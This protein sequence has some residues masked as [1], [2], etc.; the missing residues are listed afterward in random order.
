[1]YDPRGRYR[2]WNGIASRFYLFIASG[3]HAHQPL[4]IQNWRALLALICSVVPNLPGLIGDVN[5]SI[6]V[7]GA[8]HL[9]DFAWMYGVRVG[10]FLLCTT[11]LTLCS[12]TQFF[13]A[14]FV[15]YVTSTLFPAKE[16]YMDEAILGDLIL[17]TIS[18]S[19]QV[20]FDKPLEDEKVKT[21]EPVVVVEQTR[22]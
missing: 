15:F 12:S 20:S 2:Y 22:A 3:N 9:Y 13:S 11:R 18:Q 16:T 4:S 14:S 19:S 5:S 6:S 7:G 17:P 10:S 8:A 21:V 1:M